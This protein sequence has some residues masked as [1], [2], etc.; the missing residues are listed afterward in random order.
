MSVTTS[1]R[2]PGARLV[3]EIT[4]HTPVD[5]YDE[6]R[7]ALLRKLRERGI[8]IAIDDVGAG[9]S[10]LRHVLHLDPEIIKLDQDVTLGVDLDSGRAKLVGT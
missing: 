8:R 9:F 1:R 3:L 2:A 5:D 6:L 7:Q 4:E 10:T